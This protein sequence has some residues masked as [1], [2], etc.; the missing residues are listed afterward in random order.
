MRRCRAPLNPPVHAVTVVG[1]PFITS[2][3]TQD[4]D[5]D[6]HFEHPAD[7]TRWLGE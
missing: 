7:A 3:G 1:P 2:A 6:C 4:C 5:E